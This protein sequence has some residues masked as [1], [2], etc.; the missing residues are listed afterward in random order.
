MPAGL[1]HA[2]DLGARSGPRACSSAD[3]DQGRVAN[4]GPDAQ[5]CLVQSALEGGLAD[6]GDLG[7]LL[8]GESLDVTQHEGVSQRRRQL[9][10]GA[11]QCPA[12]FAVLG[13]PGWVESGWRG[14]LQFV[15]PD[16]DSCRAP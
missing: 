4:G 2:C 1:H 3:G 13:L 9:G 16:R 12:Q 5:P 11:A 14:Q 15:C 8:R 6:P 7:G 10:Q